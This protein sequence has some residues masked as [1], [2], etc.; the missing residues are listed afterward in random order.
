MEYNFFMKEAY[1]EALKAYEINEVPIG[2]VITYNNQII[3][4]AY[5]RRNIEKNTLKHA[6]IIAI[7]KACK[8][9]GD[10]RLEGCNIFVTVEPCPM[11]AGAILQ[12]RIDKLIFA[13]RN[14]KAGCCGSVLNILNNKQFNHSVDIIEGVLLDECSMLMKNFFKDLRRKDKVND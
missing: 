1:K 10:W 11:C 14:N 6:E 5:N 12:S 9:L 7:D 8:V 4:R 2:C 3:S 13:T